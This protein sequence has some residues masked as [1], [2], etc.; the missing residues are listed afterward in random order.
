MKAVF[1]R[2]EMVIPN[3][4]LNCIKSFPLNGFETI[5]YT[6]HPEIHK[7]YLPENIKCIDSNEILPTILLNKLKQ[8][9]QKEHW[10]Y[11]AFSDFFRASIMKKF[12]GSWYFD[13][14]VICIKSCDDFH[15]LSS[16]AKGRIIVGRQSSEIING[17]IFSSNNLKIT[18]HYLN[19]LHSF[20]KKKNYSHGW[21][22]TGP[23]FVT[24]Y[25][26]NFPENVFVV[27][28]SYF[29][30]I[31][32]SEINYFYDP[33]FAEKGLKR[34]KNSYCVH[35]WSEVFKMA[36]IPT[37]ILPPESSFLNKLIRERVEINPCIYL[38]EETALK[39]LYPP[40]WG[41]KKTI[42]NIIPAFLKYVSKKLKL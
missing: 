28:K 30:E 8:I 12:P 17:A 23:S 22:E 9:S 20:S 3:L 15:K 29:Y 5:I 27:D 11:I 32:P 21:G 37:N 33:L 34:I 38:P 41:L 18:D 6:T 16:L 14:D 13:N 4:W 1:F 24:W 19:L 40:K 35:M 25:C 39:L 42:L 36:C 2:S 26:K 10:H 31:E 7:K